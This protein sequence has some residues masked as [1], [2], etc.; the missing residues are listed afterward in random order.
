[1]K[2]R[3]IY[4]YIREKYNELYRIGYITAKTRNESAREFALKHTS[5]YNILEEKKRYEREI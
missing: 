4:K 3:F 2:C 1:M 5:I